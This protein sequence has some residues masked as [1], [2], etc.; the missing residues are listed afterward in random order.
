M[1]R[2]CPLTAAAQGGA[3][4]PAVA[5]PPP[6]AARMPPQRMPRPPTLSLTLPWVPHLHATTYK[7]ITYSLLYSRL[8]LV[9]MCKLSP[10]SVYR[11]ALPHCP[12]APNARP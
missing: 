5:L 6:A 4:I 7:V 3:R 2:S 10:C 8:S 11:S 12:I 1:G 9:F